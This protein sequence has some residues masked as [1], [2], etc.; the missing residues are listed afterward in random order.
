[1]VWPIVIGI[2][3][4]VGIGSA[5][6]VTVKR[7]KWQKT[8]NEAL[9]NCRKTEAKAKTMAEEFNREA[10]RLGQ[11]RISGVESRKDAA[12]FIRKA[13]AKHLELES[14][15][16]IPDETLD[17]WKELHYQAVKSI[18]TGAAGIA[19]AAG[20]ATAT[21][22]GLY[23]AAGL[24]GVASTGVRISTLS[25]AAAHSAKLA[26]LGGGALSAGGVGMAG[27][28]SRLI[29]AANVVAT[30]IAI[31][32]SVWGEW[33]AEQMKNNV[34]AKLK[35]FAKAEAKMRQQISVMRSAMPRMDELG[36]AIRESEMALKTQ[37]NKSDADNV[38]EAHKVYKI[39]IALA[40]VL[41]QPVLTEHQK[42]VLEG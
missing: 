40:E 2:G 12:E 29:L 38:D 21:V 37:I 19:G 13:K 23:K 26:W 39:A 9:A 18:G 20:A 15:D 27:G 25:G 34:E 42:E 31:A 16:I 17:S 35:E 41:E 33:K 30:P 6:H 8:H 24:F 5:I 22:A 36:K 28:L 1:M 11:M 14:L 7:R 3:V 32:A 4:A 10:E